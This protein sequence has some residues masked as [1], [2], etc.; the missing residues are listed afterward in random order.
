M[1]GDAPGLRVCLC[2][3]VCV[4]EGENVGGWHVVEVMNIHAECPCGM[5]YSCN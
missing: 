4:R 3:R 2:L 1:A 5:I